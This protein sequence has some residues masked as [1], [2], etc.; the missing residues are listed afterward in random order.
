[1]KRAEKNYQKQVDKTEKA[2]YN[3]TNKSETDEKEE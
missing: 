3:K 2:T 1:M